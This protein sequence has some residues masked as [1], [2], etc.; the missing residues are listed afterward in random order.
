METLPAQPKTVTKEM[1]GE[2]T[3][4]ELQLIWLIRNRFRFGEI[5]MQVRDGAPFRIMKAF[6]STD[7]T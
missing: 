5:L 3:P 7:L 1:I 4:K 2:L 6:E